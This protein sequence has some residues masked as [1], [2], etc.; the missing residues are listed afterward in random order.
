[1]LAFYRNYAYKIHLLV[2][3]IQHSRDGLGTL[4]ISHGALILARV[5]LLEVEL[6]TRGLAAPQTK[7]VAGWGLVSGNWIGQ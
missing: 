7:V 3:G 5:E 6:S 2:I 4:L 1:L